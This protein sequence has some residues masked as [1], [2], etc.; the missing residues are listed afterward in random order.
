MT[1]TLCAQEER[2]RAGLAQGSLDPELREHA[3]TC[4]TCREVVAI[5]SWMR[6]LQTATLEEHAP[7]ARIPGARDILEQARNR[8]L[9]ID[10][11]D[12]LKPLRLYRRIVL[13]LGVGAGIIAAILNASSIK[14][15]LLSLPGLRTLISGL[16]TRPAG[17]SPDSLVM[18]GILFGLG[19]VTVLVL[20]VAARFKPAER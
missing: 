16:A 15:F 19:F 13:P 14:S 8:R 6:Q 3:A 10:A 17:M 4:P 11:S 1:D 5:S 18:V 7:Q 12:V 9:V 2:I 20:A